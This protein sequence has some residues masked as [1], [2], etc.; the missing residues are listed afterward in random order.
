MGNF[1]IL[2][3]LIIHFQ[4][5]GFRNSRFFFRKLPLELV[6]LRPDAG[7]GRFRW[8]GGFQALRASDE[9]LQ[10]VRS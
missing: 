3:C 9:V 7:V 5:W 4:R 6:K 8:R 10:Q 2:Y 1:S